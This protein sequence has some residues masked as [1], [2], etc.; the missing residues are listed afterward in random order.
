MTQMIKGKSVFITGGAGFIGAS[1]AGKLLDHN[2]VTVYDNFTRNS[3]MD[4]SFCDHP[5]LQI[6]KGDILDYDSLSAA[7][8]GSE[9]I[10]HC[11]AIAGIDTVVKS[12]ITTMRVNMVGSANV[13]EAASRLPRCERVVCFSTSE[14][15]RPAGF[16]FHGNGQRRNRQDRRSPLDVR[17]QQAGRRAPGHIVFQ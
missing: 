4:K 1:I 7:M 3:L 8:E 5:N 10:V 16:Q 2:R 9:I 14:V 17:G 13:L 6:V 11:A 15:F 12:P